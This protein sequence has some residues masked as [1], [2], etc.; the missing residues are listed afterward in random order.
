ISIPLHVTLLIPFLSLPQGCQ[1]IKIPTENNMFPIF[2]D[3]KLIQLL[4]PSSMPMSSSTS[5][6]SVT[7][8]K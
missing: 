3:D 7:S 1:I 5:S 4:P 2:Y 6:S 8:R